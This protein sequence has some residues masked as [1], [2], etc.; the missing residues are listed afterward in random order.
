[1]A[2]R[3][4]RPATEWGALAEDLCAK[5]DALYDALILLETVIESELDGVEWEYDIDADAMG[6]AI[7]RARKTMEAAAAAVR[8]MKEAQR[9][10]GAEGGQKIRQSA[11]Q[12]KE[13]ARRDWAAYC[14]N[15]SHRETRQSPSAWAEA[16]ANKY[17]K[18][19][20]T[21]YEAIK[22]G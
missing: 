10:A 11:E 16:N 3:N 15:T 7:A 20:R 1:M 2:K 14:A 9:E 13:R 12:W 5:A 18:R 19:P 17:G 8:A 4:R 21:V 22:S 6:D